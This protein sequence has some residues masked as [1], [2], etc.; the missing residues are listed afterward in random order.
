MGRKR[1]CMLLQGSRMRHP[2]YIAVGTNIKLHLSFSSPSKCMPCHFIGSGQIE[3]ACNRQ[4][5]AASI[6][7]V[8]PVAPVLLASCSSLLHLECPTSRQH[9]CMASGLHRWALLKCYSIKIGKVI[10]KS[11]ISILKALC[12]ISQGCQS[13]AAGAQ[14]NYLT[15]RAI[16]MLFVVTVAVLVQCKFAEVDAL[17]SGKCGD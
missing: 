10:A 9:R 17:L 4:Q 11:G 2:H 12:E 7:W 16:V 6:R 3:L 15:H 1:A 5:N 13:A 14:C 8:R